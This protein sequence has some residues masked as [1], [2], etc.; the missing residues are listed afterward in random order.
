MRYYA[1]VVRP[2]FEV[3]YVEIEGDDVK[4]GEQAADLAL[5]ESMM[6]KLDWK[7]LPFDRE[8]YAPHVEMLV[9]DQELTE[10]D[11]TP[12]LI[13]RWMRSSDPSKQD[14][15]LLLHADME[16]GEG[17]TILQ[18]WLSEVSRPMLADLCAEWMGHQADLSELAVRP[19]R[20]TAGPATI[21]PFRPRPRAQENGGPSLD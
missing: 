20:P 17:R 10:S 11:A 8:A 21:I 15:Y 13:R 3:A 2:R 18:P 6:A 19:P 5:D 1:K 16:T 9:S 12:A 4:T 14:R 7:M